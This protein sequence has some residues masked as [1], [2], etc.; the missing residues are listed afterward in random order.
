MCLV[1]GTHN[2]KSFVVL[3]VPPGSEL[4]RTPQPHVETQIHYWLIPEPL[5]ACWM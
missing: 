4:W 3:H 1:Y 5:S 2:I